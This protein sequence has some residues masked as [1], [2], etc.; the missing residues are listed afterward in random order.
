MTTSLFV[1]VIKSGEGDSHKA[2]K[3]ALRA[4]VTTLLGIESCAAAVGKYKSNGSLRGHKVL[5]D[6]A[7]F[8]SLV[9]SAPSELAKQIAAITLNQWDKC[10]VLNQV[11]R[12]HWELDK[13]GKLTGQPSRRIL[14]S[15]QKAA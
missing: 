9:E 12:R 6:S 7:A 8:D 10:Q 1:P 15:Q 14:L 3:S 13:R 5:D 11:L 2:S 4:L